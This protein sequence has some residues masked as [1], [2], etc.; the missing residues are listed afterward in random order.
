MKTKTPATIEDLYRVPGKAE[1]VNGEIVLMP[2]TGDAPSRAGLHI[3]SSLL[4]Y[5]KRTRLGRVYPDNAAFVVD[6]PHRKSFSPDAAFY[7]GE[8][9]KGLNMK[10]VVGAPIFVAEVRSEGDYGQAA[11]KRMS[12]KRSDYFE[13]GTQIVWDVDL[14]SD[15]VVRA[16][17]ADDPVKPTIYLRGEV[18]DAEPFLPGWTM[19]V[20]DLFD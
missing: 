15:E 13:A 4:D 9:P 3:S 12:D 11:E 18:A 7:M 16:Y 1:L 5:E 10:F 2:P 8:V 20:D 6:L 19:P 14:R 17:R